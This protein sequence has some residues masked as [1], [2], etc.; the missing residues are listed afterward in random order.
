MFRKSRALSLKFHGEKYLVMDSLLALSL[1]LKA[2]ANK[3]L[4]PQVNLRTQLEELI[5]QNQPTRLN[6]K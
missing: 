5:G 3:K 4:T 6:G 1:G 2:L